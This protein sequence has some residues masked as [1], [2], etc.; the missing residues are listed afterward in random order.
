VILDGRK[1]EPGEL[2]QADICVIGSGAAGITA[3][4]ELA[5]R[6]VQVLLLEAGGPRADDDSQDPARGELEPGTDHGP[7]ELVRQRRLGGTTTQWGGRCAPLQPIDFE[8]R[9]WLAGSGWPIDYDA[10]RPYY[11]R[12]Q[13]YCDLG[14][15]EYGE[16][17][18]L[19][20]A[21]PF[22]PARDD[23]RLEDDR[24]WRWSPPVNFW[25]R[26]RRR[27]EASH[28]LRVVH[29][30]NVLRL[31]RDTVGGAVE[32]AEVAGSPGRTFEVVARCFVLAAG[33]LE[34]ARLLLASNRQTPAGIGNEQDL[35]GRFYMTHPVA[36][37]GRIE[38]ADPAA[39]AVAGGFLFTHDSVY[40]RRMMR[41][42]DDAQREH[43]LLNL[44]LAL[45]Y[46]EP[47]DP[48]H[49]D[50]LLST[51]ALVRAGMARWRVDWKSTGV[52]SR[53]QEIQDVRGHLANVARGLPAVGS[54][55]AGWAR[56][57]WMAKRTL[58]SFMTS[59]AAGVMRLRFDA[60]QS[61]EA[62]NRVML[63]RERDAYGV[64][65]LSLAYRVSAS[66]RESIARSLALAG[67]ELERLGTAR[68]EL[69][70]EEGLADVK[71]GDGT[72]QLGLTRMSDNPR[73]GVVDA[74][75]RVHGAPN[76]AVASSS[77]FPTAG[78]VGPTLTI[79][80]LAVRAAE[81]LARELATPARL[82]V[83][84]RP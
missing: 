37:V 60:E 56:R 58:P 41:L 39:A 57:R 6:G 43:R 21:A 7:L 77:V 61:P 48:T 65:R 5:R 49:S 29:H 84:L 82:A 42:S 34:S 28:G 18:A 54:Y 64:P 53:Y 23:A 45:W 2:L 1:I 13:E 66:D 14:A 50:A 22:L 62:G 81:D 35:V 10:V 20:G 8:Q 67:A 3:A 74:R 38:L 79:V 33:G 70:P 11:L 51:F 76:L 12:A 24:L 30:A 73:R 16:R 46:P 68:V 40:C 27:L 17:D 25:R 78:A 19:P 83:D 63:T 47:G 52:H 80:A 71:L 32:R 26:Y 75:C 69:P 4:L 36:E 15:F 55:G 72:H 59:P 31:D 44:A 9:D